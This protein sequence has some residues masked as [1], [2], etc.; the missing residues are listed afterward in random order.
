M[1]A[2]ERIRRIAA[3][4]GTAGDAAAAPRHT[5]LLRNQALS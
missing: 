4:H 2:I 3:P 5:N 1:K